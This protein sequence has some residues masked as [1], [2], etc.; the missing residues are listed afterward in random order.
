[1]AVEISVDSDFTIRIAVPDTP[2]VGSTVGFAIRPEKI[3]VSR[4]A[5]ANAPV[6][7]ARG[8]IWDIGYLGDMT[9]F[10]IKLASGQFVRA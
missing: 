8:E 3:R 7:A 5:P 4:A 2:A 6:N 1:G 10:H 9:V